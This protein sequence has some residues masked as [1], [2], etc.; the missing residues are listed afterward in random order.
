VHVLLYQVSFLDLVPSVVGVVGDT[1]SGSKKIISYGILY[2]SFVVSILAS[3]CAGVAQ[4]TEKE[5]A[6][7]ISINESKNILFFL[8]LIS[9]HSLSLIT[10]WLSYG[11]MCSSLEG[12][13]ANTLSTYLV[14]TF[15][16]IQRL[17]P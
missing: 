12:P 17:P 7:T 4:A 16:H 2:D 11:H 15:P 5:L 8:G 14:G 9:L 6:T 3:N 10:I 13:L 1:S